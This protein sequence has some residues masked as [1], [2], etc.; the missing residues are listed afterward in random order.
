[1]IKNSENITAK[2]LTFIQNHPLYLSADRRLQELE[3]TRVFC[4]HQMN[5]LLD[6]ARIAYILNLEMKLGISR[7]LIYA[8][9]LLHDIGKGRQ[10]EEG[11]P[12][13]TA[14]A[15]LAEQI[16]ADMPAK[17]AFTSEE[18]QQILTAIRGHRRLR[19]DAEPLEAL[20]YKSDKMSR[21][22]F[23]CPAESQ[24]N[25]SNDKK[26]MEIQL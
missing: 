4:R 11:I 1:M 14:S 25:W 15:D 24:C 10:Y 2:R 9:A 19:R 5:H 6:V 22:C 23:A 12:H 8:A 26:N 20:L 21:A 17:L 13:E 7:D 3:E 16:L 18:Q